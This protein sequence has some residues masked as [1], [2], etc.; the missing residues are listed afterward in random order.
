VKLFR[1]GGTLE[2]SSGAIGPSGVHNDLFDVQANTAKGLWNLHAIPKSQVGEDELCAFLEDLKRRHGAPP[3]RWST[4]TP[5]VVIR[6]DVATASVPVGPFVKVED[7]VGDDEEILEDWRSS[8]SELLAKLQDPST[9]H[10]ELFEAILFS[11]IAQFDESQTEQLLTR[12]FAFVSEYRLS[13]EEAAITAVGAAIRRLAMNLQDSQIE[14]YADLFLPT[15]TDTL[16]CEIE[17][18]LAKAILWRLATAPASLSDGYPKLECRL[19]ELTLD[20]L[21]PRL[22][23]QKNYASVAL[24][25]ALG[26]LLLNDQHADSVLKS[27]KHLGIGWFSRLFQRRL[28]KLQR[29]LVETG[30]MT[31]MAV[32]SNLG[33]FESELQGASN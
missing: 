31:S 19:A 3:L 10:D 16:P 9:C 32:A 7:R 22:I 20:Y 30:D 12:L 26:V 2:I 33:R 5:S 8:P 29:R 18:E 15:D 11:E 17:L 28:E 24:Q 27:V 25:A 14:Q 6:T 23:L 1:W 13:Q 4:R 21:K